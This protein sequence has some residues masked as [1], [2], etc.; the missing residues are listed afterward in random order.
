MLREMIK[1]EIGRVQAGHDPKGVVR[2][3]DHALI[4]TNLTATINH[5]RHARPSSG[6]GARP[7]QVA[8]RREEQES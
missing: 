5:M 7:A 2:D 4:D 3:P 1:R 8:A 6:S